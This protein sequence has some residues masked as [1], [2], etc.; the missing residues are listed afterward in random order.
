MYLSP[1]SQPRNRMMLPGHLRVCL[2][3]SSQMLAGIPSSVPSTLPHLSTHPKQY[4]Q[5]ASLAPALPITYGSFHSGVPPFSKS[6]ANTKL[7]AFRSLLL[8]FT[9]SVKLEGDH[10]SFFLSFPCL[11]TTLTGKQIPRISTTLQAYFLFSILITTNLRAHVF[12][13]DFPN[14]FL[15]SFPIL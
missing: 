9:W 4:H 3:R 6:T 12:S 7:R 14:G 13:P 8:L 10:Q 5:L 15:H 1:I 2:G 11:S